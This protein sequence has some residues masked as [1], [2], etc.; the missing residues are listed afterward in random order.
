MVLKSETN[1]DTLKCGSKTLGSRANL[2][3]RP[4]HIRIEEFQTRKPEEQF[5]NGP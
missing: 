5:Q 3:P 2:T 4:T 1:C